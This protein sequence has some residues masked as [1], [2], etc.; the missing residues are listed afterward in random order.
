MSQT[1]TGAERC[2]PG[3]RAAQMRALAIGQTISFPTSYDAQKAKSGARRYKI[4]LR[5]SGVTLE[6]IA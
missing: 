4:K 5:Q 6:R 3:E 2:R 1:I